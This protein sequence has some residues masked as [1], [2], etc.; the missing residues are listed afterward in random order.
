[1][2]KIR[3]VAVRG[4]V[5]KDSV[6]IAAARDAISNLFAYVTVAMGFTRTVPSFN[7]A[8]IHTPRGIGNAL[9]STIAPVM[10]WLAGSSW[11]VTDPS[12][13]NLF[14]WIFDSYEP[15]I[16]RGAALD[17]VRGREASPGPTRV[18]NRLGIR[19]WIPSFKS[20]NLHRH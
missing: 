2:W 1:M 18:R 3:V 9:L 10:N 17:L 15:I 7:T 8:F 19:S 5:V 20:L 16:Y 13:A 11:A 14:R 4:A 12:Q 6:K